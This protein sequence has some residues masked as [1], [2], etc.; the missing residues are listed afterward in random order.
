MFVMGCALLGPWAVGAPP[1][2][3]RWWGGWTGEAAVRDHCVVPRMGQGGVGHGCHVRERLL[4]MA[5]DGCW[6]PGRREAQSCSPPGKEPGQR[7][8][9]CVGCEGPCCGQSRREWGV[10]VPMEL[11]GG[12][13][14]CAGSSASARLLPMGSCVGVELC[15]QCVQWGCVALHRWLSL[16]SGFGGNR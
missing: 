2:W 12:A 6:L 8:Q 4:L 3:L 16:T 1:C 15:P 13:R 14:L 10:W 9:P 7:P 5:G 11:E